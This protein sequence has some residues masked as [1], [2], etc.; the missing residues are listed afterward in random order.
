M[1]RQISKVG[2]YDIVELIARGGMGAVYKAKHPTL[3]RFVILKQLTLRGGSGFIQ[4]FKREASLMIDFRDEHIV[5]VYDHFKE[6]SSYYIAMEYVDGIGLD[7]LIENIGNLSNEAAILIFSEVCKGIKYAH[8]K[9]V[10]HRDIKPANILISKEG[11]VKLVDF[12]IATSKESDDDGLTKA[13]MTLGTPAYMSP[14]QIS[15][16][17]NV[18]KR[19]DV[20][21]MGVVLY[22]MLTGKKP[23]PGGF[24]REAINLINKGI[25]TKPQKINP[26]IPGTIRRVITKSMNH[27]AAKRYKDVQQIVDSLSKYTRKYKDRE[28]IHR[29]IKQ[30]IKGVKISLPSRG[31]GK[32]RRWLK[33]KIAASLI[34]LLVIVLGCLYF[35][36]K[37]HY[38]EYFKKNE[39]GSVEIRSRI[40]EDFSKEPELIYSFCRL[41]PLGTPKSEDNN[42]YD[43]RLSP[44][45]GSVLNRFAAV[46][47]KEAEGE[48]E[49]ENVLTTGI[50]Y[51]PEG[52]Y[53]LELYLENA[54]FFKTFYLNPRTVQQQNVKTYEKQVLSFDLRG[55]SPKPVTIIPR[56]YDSET[57]ISLY[58]ASDIFFYLKERDIW[59]DWKRYQSNSRLKRYLLNNITSG[60]HYSFRFKAH[61]YYPETVRFYVENELDVVRVEVG[62]IKK[63]G[64]LVVESDYEGLKLLIDGREENYLG[65][66]EKDFVSYG[67]TIV[68][69]KEFFLS[70]GNYLLTVIKDKRRMENYQFSVKPEGLTR[71]KVSYNTD[72]KKIY[73]E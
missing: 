30:Y 36:W 29:D 3:K 22:E 6:G 55:I 52:R 59:I 10:I 68:G 67:Q 41:T 37:G 70:E 35:Y 73:V 13:G 49:E 12:G 51:L 44:V 62:L 4:R 24:T 66:K 18:D 27:K 28:E 21:S 50:V 38:Y 58:K 23:F 63:P 47:S 1:P 48:N 34:V 45:K 9:N 43:F 65:E 26:T 72:E 42:K 57:G 17:K 11:E 46:F 5:Q 20:Y 53:R 2:K 8:D 39:F 71:L 7:Q 31:V 14:E 60:S 25:Y 64:K 32:R 61:S 33:L 16:T 54:K 19:A 40:P 56:V 69:K 15:D